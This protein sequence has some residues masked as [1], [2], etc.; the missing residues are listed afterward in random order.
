[1]EQHNNSMIKKLSDTKSLVEILPGLS[2]AIIIWG[3]CSEVFF[4]K[5]F[6]IDIT[7]FVDTGELLLSF[8]DRLFLSILAAF[9]VLLNDIVGDWIGKGR[10]REVETER[11]NKGLP[12]L[13]ERQMRVK[14]WVI[15]SIVLAVFIYIRFTADTSYQI[16][17]YDF[18]IFLSAL[19]I[20]RFY[21][22][23]EM[24]SNFLIVIIVIIAVVGIIMMDVGRT[25]GKR[26]IQKGNTKLVCFKYGNQIVQSD[27]NYIFIGKSNNY[28]FMYNRG[29]EVSIV[30]KVDSVDS[31]SFKEMKV[32]SN[33]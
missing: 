33:R 16:V 15:I 31:L 8:V 6:N 11:E 14:G 19:R 13:D 28:L 17:F 12:K 27:S 29:L 9:V 26:L 7:S 21:H 2:F 30:Y 3:I 1:M 23:D 25:E 32:A 4:Y 5:Q 22:G 24:R 18:T 10:R 20:Y